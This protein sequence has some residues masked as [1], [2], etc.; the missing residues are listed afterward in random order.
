ML[1]STAMPSMRGMNRSSSQDV[2]A[3]R[4]YR[5]QCRD[6]VR[7]LARHLDARLG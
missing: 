7:G 4:A 1:R 6:P 5:L 2:G 3:Q